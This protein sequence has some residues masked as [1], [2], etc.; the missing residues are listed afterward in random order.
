MKYAYKAVFFD[1]DGTILDT[2]D[3]LAVALNAARVASGFPEH[4]LDDVRSHVGNGVRR[5]VEWSV[6]E[7]G[8]ETI[9]KVMNEYRSFYN[10]HCIE[11]TEPY[12]GIKELMTDLKAEGVKVFV[13]TNKSDGP[14]KKLCEHNFPGLIDEVR[15]HVDG[16]PHKPDPT[17]VNEILKKF[18]LLPEDCCYIGDSDVDLRTGLNSGMTPINVTWGYKSKNFLIESGSK[19]MADNIDELRYIL[20]GNA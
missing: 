15:G 4:D 8:E 9:E 5:L 12:P 1:L 6:G 11:N 19:I 17:L 16:I 7:Y 10:A 13:V 3:Q 20:E 18:G 2:I 14:A